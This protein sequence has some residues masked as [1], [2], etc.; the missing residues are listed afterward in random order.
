M[1]IENQ[2]CSPEQAKK[3]WDLGIVQNGYFSWIVTPHRVNDDPIVSTEKTTNNAI[4]SV[5]SAFTAAELIEMMPPNIEDG[6]R[7]WNGKSQSFGLWRRN[8]PTFFV[9]FSPFGMAYTD[10]E[11]LGRAINDNLAIA[12]AEILIRIIEEGYVSIGWINATITGQ[13]PAP[14]LM[15]N[16]IR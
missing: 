12:C 1:K 5:F 11:Y 4:K 16:K 10:E 15:N 3:L 14:I 6:D 2:V 8:D 7:K 13:R 9:W